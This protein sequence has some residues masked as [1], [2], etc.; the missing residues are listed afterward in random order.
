MGA[1]GLCPIA[2]LRLSA[3]GDVA[4]VGAVAV[5]AERG[6]AAGGGAEPVARAATG[7]IGDEAGDARLLRTQ[8]LAHQGDA[9]DVLVGHAIRAPGEG[10]ATCRRARV[11]RADGGTRGC[12]AGAAGELAGGH[13]V[14]L[15]AG[16]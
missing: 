16:G 9:E 1:L 2:R 8:A 14:D 12:P 7:S 15:P 5:V 3:A 6:R 4:A 13:G 10:D 11:Q